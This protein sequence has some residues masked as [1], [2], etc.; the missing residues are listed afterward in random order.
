MLLLLLG[1]QQIQRVYNNEQERLYEN[2]KFHHPRPGFR[3]CSA[4]VA[5]LVIHTLY[6]VF[7]VCLGFIVPFEKFSLIWRSHHF[8]W[9]A[10]K[11]YLCS[12]LS[13]EQWGF[14]SVP[15]LLWHGSSIYKG[16]LQGPVTLTSVAEHLA[17]ELSLPVFMT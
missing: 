14:F 4:D 17:V 5:S 12:A 3:G 2:F 8:Q 1:M 6:S 15:H 11:F 16:N 7:F 10:A 13:I 9:R